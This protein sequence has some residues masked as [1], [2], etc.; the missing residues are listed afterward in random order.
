MTRKAAHDV[1]GADGLVRVLEQRCQSCIFWSGNRAHLKPGRF[2]E[3]VQGNL[4]ADALLTCHE[5]LPGSDID[6]AVCAGF[7]ARHRRDV[8]TGRLAHLIGISRVP[9]PAQP[10]EDR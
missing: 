10:K 6:P 1:I 4:K 3:V 8:L 9:P 7:W 5:T 2:E